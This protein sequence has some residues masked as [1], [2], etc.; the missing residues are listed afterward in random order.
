ML[1]AFLG[2]ADSLTCAELPA[3]GAERPA[4]SDAAPSPSVFVAALAE[5]VDKA[6]VRGALREF[7]TIKG[8]RIVATSEGKAAFVDFESTEEASKAVAAKTLAR[9]PPVLGSLGNSVPHISFSLPRKDA[10]ATPSDAHGRTTS[11]TSP[12][13][14]RTPPPPPPSSHATTQPTR[15]SCCSRCPRS[16][17]R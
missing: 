5:A 7:G 13:I 11:Q 1:S 9:P 15:R 10:A 16:T 6:A 14:G 17:H 8:C 3:R 12:R 2:M 4:S